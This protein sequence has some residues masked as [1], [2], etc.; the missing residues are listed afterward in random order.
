[1]FLL[2]WIY[3]K[4]GTLELIFNAFTVGRI[5]FESGSVIRINK[6]NCCNPCRQGQ[7]QD[8]SPLH[9]F[10]FKY[11]GIHADVCTSLFTFLL[12]CKQCKTIK[13]QKSRLFSSASTVGVAYSMNC[14]QKKILF[15][16][17]KSSCS[18]LI[19]FSYTSCMCWR[20]FAYLCLGQ[21]VI[22]S[23]AC[24]FVRFNFS[25]NQRLHTQPL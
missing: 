23:C 24:C 12:I 15:C 9:E 4:V 21:N 6:T 11:R 8:C 13:N 3:Q 2:F 18:F 20:Q 22:F 25:I 14:W 1:M 16:F 5:S 19:T 10:Q 17:Y 7:T